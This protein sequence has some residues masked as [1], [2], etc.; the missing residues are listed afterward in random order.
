[1]FS[2][3]SYDYPNAKNATDYNFSA[4]SN[5]RTV[6]IHHGDV[7]S[8]LWADGHTSNPRLQIFRELKF[9]YVKLNGTLIKL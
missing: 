4:T 1:M 6:S 2:D 5:A 8:V 3:T 9:L 7:G